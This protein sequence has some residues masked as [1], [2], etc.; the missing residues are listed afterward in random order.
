MSPLPGMRPFVRFN[1]CMVQG[2][3]GRGETQRHHRAALH[4]ERTA[5][6]VANRKLEGEGQRRASF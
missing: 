4:P 3:I 5:D 6:A 1:G 2:R